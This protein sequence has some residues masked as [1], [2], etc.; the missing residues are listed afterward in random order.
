MADIKILLQAGIHK[1]SVEQI[2]KQLNNLSANIKTIDIKI[3]PNSIKEIQGLESSLSKLGALKIAKVDMSGV[4][5]SMKG[6]AKATNEYNQSLHELIHLYK[7]QQIGANDFVDMASKYRKESEFRN[8]SDK[9]QI[10]LVQQLSKADK[11][12][13]K[14]LDEKTKTI[15][16]MSNEEEKAQQKLLTFQQKMLGVGDGDGQLDIFGQKFKGKFDTNELANIRKEVEGLY[17]LTPKEQEE[18][19]KRL[20]VQFGNLKQSAQQSG[21]VLARTF[22]NMTKFLRYYAAGGILVGFVREIRSGIESVKD[23]DTSLTE[24]NKISNMS[25][26]QMKLFTDR[27]YEAGNEIARTGKEVV[28]ATVE[29][30][31]AGFAMEEA[32]QLAQQ[33]LLLTNV[34]S[35][36]DN[37]VEASSSMIAILKGFKMEAQ[38]SIHIVDSLNEVSNNYAVDTVNL[39]EILKRVSGAISQTGTSYE[40]LIG[41]SVG[42]FESLRNSEKVASGLNMITQRLKGN[43]ALYVQ[44]C[45]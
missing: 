16:K 22:E 9:Q 19:M 30:R 7:T 14:V 27:A 28:D 12:H 36:I 17:A 20:N 33:S 40:E 26:E 45:A 39:T 4:D 6:A 8:L 35:G 13:T 18:G 10:Q 1:D 44:K 38:D 3:N 24:L 29:W 11:E 43:V 5:N 42:G 21:S 34:G 37:V 31:R 32:L 23:L 15:R 2:K 25:S 41:L